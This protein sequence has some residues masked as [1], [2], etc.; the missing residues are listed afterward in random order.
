[1]EGLSYGPLTQAIGALGKHWLRV[2]PQESNKV[3]VDT[4]HLGLLL[5]LLPACPGAPP[6]PSSSLTRLFVRARGTMEDQ[7]GATADGVSTGGLA[8]SHFSH[9][10]ITI[11]EPGRWLERR[12][13]T[14]SHQDNKRPPPHPP[15][16][17]EVPKKASS[18]VGQLTERRPHQRPEW[19]HPQ[20]HS[21][22]SEAM[23]VSQDSER[24]PALPTDIRQAAFCFCFC[25][26][27]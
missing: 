24:G 27:A 9:R 10:E 11:V 4:P 2:T 17:T 22:P 25:F 1:M 21:S 20:I 7:D 12:E 3:A 18:P 23:R 5:W 14:S 16:P 15:H 13:G 8:H 19:D 6:P 26:F